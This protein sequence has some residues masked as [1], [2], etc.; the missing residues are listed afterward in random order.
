MTTGYDSKGC[1][2]LG[3]LGDNFGDAE[4]GDDHGTR[5]SIRV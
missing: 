3:K 4:Q 2:Y 1:G 5:I